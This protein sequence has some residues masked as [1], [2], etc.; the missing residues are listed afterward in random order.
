MQWSDALWCFS[1]VALC[2]EEALILSRTRP[3]S[4]VRLALKSMT[5]EAEV[6][7]EAVSV[8]S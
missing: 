6:R 4:V 5:A 8:S 3:E 2:L 7:S 1:K